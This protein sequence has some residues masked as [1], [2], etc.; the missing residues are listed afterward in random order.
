MKVIKKFKKKTFV[1][2]RAGN[3]TGFTNRNP[4]VG[5]Y[6]ENPSTRQPRPDPTR[7][8][9]LSRFLRLGGLGCVTIFFFFLVGRVRFGL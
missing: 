3:C 2:R 6:K 4:E 9:E 5:V 8:A 1:N 7:P